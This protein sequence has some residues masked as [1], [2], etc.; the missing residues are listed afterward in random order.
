MKSK[1]K[2]KLIIVTVTYKST[3]DLIPFINS[4]HKYNDLGEEAKLVIVDNSPQ[5]YTEVKNIINV[6]EDITYIQCP[7]NPGFGQANNIGFKLYDSDYVLFINNDVEFLEPVFKK[8]I[9]LHESNTNVG[10]IGIHQEGGAPSFFKKFTTPP[11][12][13][14]QEFDDKYYIISGAFMFFKSNVFEKCGMF[15]K[16]LF[17]YLEE[18]DI[19]QRLN[20]NGYSTIYV[21]ELKFL[22]K[23]GNRRILNEKLWRIGAD[24]HFYICQKYN[25]NPA[26]GFYVI[27][28]R[29]RKFQLYYLITLRFK[30]I[31]KVQRILNYRNHLMA[32]TH[33]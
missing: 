21:N 3:K 10:C 7:S 2:Y 18:F 11:N 24:S 15:D 31:L 6:F 30:E 8:L 29:L 20:N 5:D 9:E 25:I 27:N 19:S 14:K 26:T 17:M 13:N 4:F 23:V 33:E 32:Q 12:I 28:R 1:E 16:N 22:H